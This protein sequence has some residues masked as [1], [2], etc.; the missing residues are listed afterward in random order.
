[1]GREQDL[2]IYAPGPLKQ[3][4]DLIFSVAN[5]CPPFKIHFHPI[6]D[7]GIIV[8]EKKFTVECFKVHH[9]IECWGFIIREKKKPRKI[10]KD[11]VDFY[12]IPAT[13]FERLKDGEDYISEDG[14]LIR[15]EDVTLPNKLGRSYAYCADTAYNEEIAEKLKDVSLVYHETTYLKD[16]EDQ[17]AKRFHST[18]IQA[19]KIALKANAKSLLIGHFSSKYQTLDEFLIE[20]TEIFP[21]TKLATEGVTYIPN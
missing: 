17:A 18:S 10:S 16:M 15:N 1:M 13:F 20:A 2:H 5:T 6:T 19:A 8:D 12:K 9:R 3:I 21:N 4:L 14:K 11:K 7:E